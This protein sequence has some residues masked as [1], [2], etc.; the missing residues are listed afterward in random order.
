MKT[1]YF[2]NIHCKYSQNMFLKLFFLYVVV[3]SSGCA[4]LYKKGVNLDGVYTIDPDGFGNFNVRC[5]MTTSGGGWTILQ[6]RVD[7]S[8]GFY[9]GWNS[10]RNGF[11]TLYNEF[12][13]GLDKI[14]RLTDSHQMVLKVDMEDFANNTYYAEY[15]IFAVSDEADNY[16]LTIGGYSG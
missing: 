6:R 2:Y 16:K 8:V 4:E 3:K 10:Y 14:N 5:D 11:G 12:W 7:G 15:S 9:R 13:L 1:Y